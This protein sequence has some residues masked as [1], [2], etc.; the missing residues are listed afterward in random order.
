MEHRYRYRHQSGL[1]GDRMVTKDSTQCAAGRAET[2]SLNGTQA[3]KW[4]REFLI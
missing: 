4:V 2:S 1:E 3:E